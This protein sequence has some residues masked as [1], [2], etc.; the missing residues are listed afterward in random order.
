MHD[1]QYCEA[2]HQYC[3]ETVEKALAKGESIL[4]SVRRGKPSRETWVKAARIYA[5]T[6]ENLLYL[7]EN[8]Q[9]LHELQLPQ[10]FRAL[11]EAEDE[12]EGE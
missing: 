4:G 8:A 5:T 9:S 12:S 6:L 10:S 11:L 2:L 1:D 3:Q 7:L